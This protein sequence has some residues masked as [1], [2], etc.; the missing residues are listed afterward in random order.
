[1]SKASAARGSRA[2]AGVTNPAKAMT[3]AHIAVAADDWDAAPLPFGCTTR[4]GVMPAPRRRLAAVSLVVGALRVTS[5]S[6]S[7]GCCRLPRPAIPSGKVCSVTSTSMVRTVLLTDS[8]HRRP[9]CGQAMQWALQAAKQGVAAA[10]TRIGLLYNNA[11]GVE[12]DV[13]AA[14]RWWR[15]AARHGN[16]DGQAM[17]GAAHHLG[18]GAERDPVTALAW[19][20][21]ART[22]RSKFADRFYDGVRNSCTPEQRREAERRA[23]LPIEAEEASP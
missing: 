13:A 23:C 20:I 2:S 8:D 15:K 6:R 3:I 14:A 18:A 11:L 19:L 9:D 4:T 5:I 17:L 16:G 1:M 21:R 22:L 12:R 7:N 10:M